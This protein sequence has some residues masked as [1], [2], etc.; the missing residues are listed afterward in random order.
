MSY[1]PLEIKKLAIRLFKS[2]EYTQAAISKIVGYSVPAVKIWIARD[3]KGLPLMA[4]AR[5]HQ[6]KK[7][8][9]NDRQL[10]RQLVAQTPDITIEGIRKALNNKASRSAVHREMVRLGFTFK[11]NE[12]RQRARKERCAA[13]ADEMG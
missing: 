3:R 12:T 2:G 6:P 11:K 4:E 9:D 5:G 8:D 7:L 13:C 10:I 1:A